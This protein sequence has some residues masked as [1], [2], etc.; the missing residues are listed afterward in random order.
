MHAPKFYRITLLSSL[1]VSQKC[2]LKLISTKNVLPI[3]SRNE[4]S[5]TLSTL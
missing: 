1:D 5:K 3:I 4:L 2:K